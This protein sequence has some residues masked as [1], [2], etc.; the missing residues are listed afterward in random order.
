T[1]DAIARRSCI[2]PDKVR[3]AIERLEAPDPQSRSQEFEGRR[4]ERID[5]HRDWGWRIVNYLHYRSLV[6][7]ETVRAQTRE[8]VRRHRESRNAGK[9]S[10]T[11]GNAGKRQAEVEAEAEDFARPSASLCATTPVQTPEPTPKGA[12]ASTIAV[13]KPRRVFVPPERDEVAAY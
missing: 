10:V 5:A 3:E 4:L 11:D 13:A 9:R 1:H 8:R 6:D 12:S 2:P 7:P